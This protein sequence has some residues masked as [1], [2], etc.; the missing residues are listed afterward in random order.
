[1]GAT[2]A[3]KAAVVK[4]LSQ[5]LCMELNETWSIKIAHKISTIIFALKAFLTRLRLSAWSV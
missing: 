1:M 3:I 2:I 4:Q 5:I